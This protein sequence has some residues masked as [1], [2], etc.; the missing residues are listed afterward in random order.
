MRGSTQW[1]LDDDS[2]LQAEPL[3]LG[4]SS[5]TE[6][7]FIVTGPVAHLAIGS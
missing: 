2:L 7:V 5:L 4:K 1:T 3:L 6:R